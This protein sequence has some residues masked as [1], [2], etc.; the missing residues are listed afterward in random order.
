M[1]VTIVHNPEAG[2]GDHSGSTLITRLRAAGHD[3]SYASTE[4]E[5][6]TR[7]LNEAPNVV[8]AA[9]GDGT[10]AAVARLLAA[11]GRDIPLAILPVGTAN[12]IARSLGV[13]T[14]VDAM[15]AALDSAG[16]RTLDVGMVRASWGKT[17]FVESAGVGLFA[18]MLRDAYREQVA[19]KTSSERAESGRGDRMRK[20]LDRA[21][22]RHWRVDADGEDLSGTYLLV[23]TLNV[24]LVGP[25]L[26]FASDAD[27][28]DGR[29]D[30]LLAG[31]EHRDAL[32]DYFDHVS[33]GGEGAL[34]I[35]TRR[36]ARARLEWSSAHG[37]VDD[38]LW[39]ET[40]ATTSAAEIAIEGPQ[41]QVLVPA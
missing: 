28:G 12:N 29:L 35:P 23:V 3:A 27:P 19:G 25:T 38:R 17:L 10:V 26:A 30:L 40:G 36:V 24:G 21:R 1:R 9:G 7:A 32:G 31:E 18:A 37:H 20:V 2:S 16:R 22:P 8:A 39:P 4:A 5:S 13:P 34:A 41:I 15:I 6:L 11:S 14:E 33:A